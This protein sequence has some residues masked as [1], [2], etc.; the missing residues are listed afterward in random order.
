[1]EIM[2][3]DTYIVEKVCDTLVRAG[4]TF[5]PDKKGAYREAIEK[6]TNEQ[7]KWVME[8]VLENA[9]AAERNHSPAMR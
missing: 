3:T 1:M 6:E 8:K 7:S 4:S 5:L 2:T 9:E